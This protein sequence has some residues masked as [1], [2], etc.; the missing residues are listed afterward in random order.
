MMGSEGHLRL[1]PDTLRVHNLLSQ[2][3]FTM[4]ARIARPLALARA[5]PRSLRD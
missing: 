3:A 4:A 5:P 2:L 1:A